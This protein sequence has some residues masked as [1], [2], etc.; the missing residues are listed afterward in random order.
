MIKYS[1][2]CSNHHRFEAW[3][4]SS[5]A[6]DRQARRQLVVCPDCG[7]TDVEKAPM[8]PALL[9]AG[10]TKTQPKPSEVLPR[11]SLADLRRFRNEIMAKAE[12]VGKNFAGEA[13]RIHFGDAEERIIRGEAT[14]EDARALLED[15]V[16]FGLVPPLPED[17][18]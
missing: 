6:F 3:F 8:A 9:K 5:D 17:Q 14:M 11:P 18:N 1:L 10:R 12:D 2:G 13:R 4:R 15:G 7:S 16:P